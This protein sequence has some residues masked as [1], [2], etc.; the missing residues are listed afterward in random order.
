MGPYKQLLISGKVQQSCPQ[1]DLLKC[2]NLFGPQ[3][4]S[5]DLLRELIGQEQLPSSVGEV[6]LFHSLHTEFAVEPSL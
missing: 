2:L 5:S 4:Q 3:T 6:Y 1:G